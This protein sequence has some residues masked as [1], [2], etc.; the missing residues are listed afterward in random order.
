MPFQIIRNDITRVSADAIVNTANPSP[1]VGGGTDTAIYKAAGMEQLLAERRKIGDIARGD[2][3]ATPAFGLKAKYI[4]HT[5]GPVW[6]GGDRGEVEILR[7]CYEKSLQLALDL[8]CE[9]IAFPLIS[10]GVYDF[11]KDLAL[12]TAISVINPFLLQ[13]EMN[14]IMV[15]FN[16]EAFQLSGRLVDNVRSYIDRNY[17]EN[18]YGFEYGSYNRAPVSSA[19]VHADKEKPRESF[20]D[21]ILKRRR[22]EVTA[23]EAPMAAESAPY[24]SKVSIDDLLDTPEKTFQEKLFEI[25]DERQLTGPQVYN[26]YITRQVYSKI[27]SD[28]NYHPNKYTAIALCLSLHL[29]LDETMDL[30]GR[31]GWTLSPSSKADLIVKACILNQEYNVINIDLILFD[32]HCPELARIK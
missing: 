21:R 5:V 9:S 19:A 29:S 2:A 14:V 23:D 22:R 26:G 30:I 31:A 4:I 3:V 8:K 28:R 12:T 11:P 32:Y 20:K 13:H 17:V 15:V 7:S 24:A 10:A 16:E 25:I 27:Q 6:K 1:V 18:A